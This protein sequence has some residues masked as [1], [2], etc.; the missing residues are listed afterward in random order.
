PAYERDN[1]NKVVKD[2]DSALSKSSL[3]ESIIVHR[4]VGDGYIAHLGADPGKPETMEALVGR[5]F[6]EQAFMSTSVGATSAF[7]DEPVQLRMVATQ[8]HM[9]ISIT[10]PSPDRDN[11]TE[12]RLA[13]IARYAI[14]AA[15]EHGDTWH[16]EA[17]VVP[18]EWKKP[19]GWAP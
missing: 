8:A 6:K 19:A 2:L 16:I 14:H 3:P 17:E 1:Y 7:D 4:G 15:S 12:V 9:A 11:A 10:P 5:D 13:R 18:A